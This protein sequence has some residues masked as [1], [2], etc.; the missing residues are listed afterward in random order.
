MMAIVSGQWAKLSVC[1]QQISYQAM[2]R[3][4][5]V[6]F[7]GGQVLLN[8]GPTLNEDLAIV[9]PMFAWRRNKTLLSKD[10]TL[11]KFYYNTG[12]ALETSGPTLK[13]H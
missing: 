10:E 9:H 7:D 5:N 6:G 11:N 3:W 12:P 13:Q 4:F 8:D 2:R 1:I